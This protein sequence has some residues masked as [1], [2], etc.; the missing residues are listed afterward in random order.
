MFCH[1]NAAVSSNPGM[2]SV[3]KCLLCHNVIASNFQP[4]AKIKRYAIPH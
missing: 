2:P 4:I 3:E 1:P